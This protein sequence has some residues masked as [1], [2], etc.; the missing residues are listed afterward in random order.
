[1]HLRFRYMAK[2]SSFSLSLS[3]CGSLRQVRLKW[4]R[5]R[6][7]RGRLGLPVLM[8]FI[9]LSGQMFCSDGD[10]DEDEKDDNWNDGDSDD[11]DGDDDGYGSSDSLS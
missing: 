11:A 1:M 7:V 4:F 8:T 6:A 9:S 3:L 10:D 5:P 2:K